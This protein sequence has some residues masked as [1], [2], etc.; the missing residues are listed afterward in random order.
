M[1][2]CLITSTSGVKISRHLLTLTEKAA[3]RPRVIRRCALI[4]IGFPDDIRQSA[5]AGFQIL[6]AQS[7]FRKFP[8]QIFPVAG[9]S[10]HHQV[11]SC[12][13]TP[14]GRAVRPFFR[15]RPVRHDQTTKAPFRPYHIGA[16]LMIIRRMDAVDQIAARHDRHRLR[17]FYRNAKA[18]QVNFPKRP[19][20]KNA[21]CAHPVVFPVIAGQMFDCRAA[22]RNGLHAVRHRRRN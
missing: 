14:G 2:P 20:R 8:N 7:P 10:R 9:R 21:V 12:P 4:S 17:F 1:M 13:H 3:G 11:V 19:L 22:S 18:P 16:D 6:P 15:R 5:D